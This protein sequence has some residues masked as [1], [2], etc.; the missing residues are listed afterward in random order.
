MPKPDWLVEAEKKIN[1]LKKA[2]PVCCDSCIYFGRFIKMTK[3]RN[4]EWTEVHE[5]DI[6]ENCF[7]TKFSIRCDDW[8]G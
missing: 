3:H 5:C 4:D 7:N 6:H 1:R 2:E 8:A